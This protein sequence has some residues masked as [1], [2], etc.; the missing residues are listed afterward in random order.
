MTVTE[1]SS[2]KLISGTGWTNPLTHN[3]ELENSTHLKVYADDT[4][5]T[6]GVN[7]TVSGVGSDS[8]YSVT[9]NTPGVWTPTTWVLSVEPPIS[10]AEDVSL[11]GVFGARF[12]EGID[13]LTRRVQRLWDGVSRSWKTPLT[14]SAS[15][16]TLTLLD[17]GHFWIADADGNMVDGG[18]G[19]DIAAAGAAGTAAVNAL[20]AITALI[21]S[22]SSY[23]I[24]S[25]TAAAGVS[26]GA[27]IQNITLGGRYA[28]GDRAGL[29]PCVRVMAMP[30]THNGWVRTADRYRSDGTIHATDGGY[31]VFQTGGFN[32]VCAFGAKGDSVTDDYAAIQGAVNHL[33]VTWASGG[34][35]FFP[36]VNGAYMCLSQV[37]IAV[38]PM[39]LR[40]E[41]QSA[42]IHAGTSDICVFNVTIGKTTIKDLTIYGS[43]IYG[44]PSSP[45]TISAITYP[46]VWFHGAQAV[47]CTLDH[48]IVYGG[49]WAIL[50]EGGDNKIYRCEASKAYGGALVEISGGHFLER[51]AF[52]HPWIDGAGLPDQQTISGSVA[53]RTN[54]TAYNKYDLRELGGYIMMCYVAG[55]SGGSAPTLRPYAMPITDGTVTWYLLAP[56]SYYGILLNTGALEV[57]IMHQD[58]SGPFSVCIGSATG[59]T[60]LNLILTD[61]TLGGAFL[62]GVVINDAYNWVMHG[63]HTGNGII[64]GTADILVSGNFDGQCTIVNNFINSGARCVYF[65]PNAGHNGSVIV[66]GNHF[67]PRLGGGAIAVGFEAA[68]DKNN[69]IVEGNVCVAGCV[70]GIKVA[71]GTSDNYAI[72]SNVNAAGMARANFIVDSGTGLNKTVNNS[73]GINYPQQEVLLFE[74]TLDCN[75]TAD[76]A[77]AIKYS[78]ASYLISRVRGENPS[79]DVSAM[80]YGLYT[81]PAAAGTQIVAAGS[82]LAASTAANLASTVSPS[83]AG[84]NTRTE[85]TLYFKASVGAGAGRTVIYSIWGYPR[86]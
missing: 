63:N 15:P 82:T 67:Q 83:A 31:W 25:W 56:V 80:V 2:R 32:N 37:N 72:S 17:E 85:Q 49:K 51:N 84:L 20:A 48:C 73:G 29:I 81:A 22:I 50:M 21:P 68:P 19:G 62:S 66:K 27:S 69:F 79:A 60:G 59:A 10:Q 9:I 28:F 44:L 4:L 12:E 61:S 38:A 33:N 77:L 35:V 70:Q 41:N 78:C 76:Q 26:V 11:G 75:S 39:T 14:E 30:T 64:Q 6:L 8:G 55:T 58:L 74:L 3:F 47:N 23:V 24:S 7:Y 53:A 34:T 54:T 1:K 46:T 45:T 65:A 40:G 43:G 86:S 52:D 18:D 13:A 5:L 16:G 71:A 57:S 42:T 36:A